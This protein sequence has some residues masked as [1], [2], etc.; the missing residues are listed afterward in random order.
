MIS[1]LLATKDDILSSWETIQSI[2]DLPEH[3]REIIICCPENKIL[4]DDRFI[5]VVDDKCTGSPYA[6]NKAYWNSEGDYIATVIDDILLPLN[7]L[8]MLDFMKSDFMKKK[9]FKISNILWDGGPGL[10]AYG[11]PYLEDGTDMWTIDKHHPVDTK[12]CP[13]SIMPLPFFERETVENLL[14]GYLFNP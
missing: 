3:D 10:Y 12:D 11:H 5:W 14:S 1:Y 6:F 2:L 9:K 13:Y 7:F 4:D 8:D